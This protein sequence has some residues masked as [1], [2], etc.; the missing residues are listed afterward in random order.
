M[1]KYLP[2]LLTAIW[3]TA[4]S[5]GLHVLWVY[6]HT[7]GSA[8]GVPGRWPAHSRIPRASE[9]PT[10]IMFAHPR[11]PCTRASIGELAVLMTHCQNQVKACV[12]FFQPKG[13]SQDWPHTDLWRSAAA[14]PGVTVRSDEDGME[15]KCFQATTSG[16]VVLYD[17]LGKLVFSGGITSSRGHAGDNVGRSKLTQWLHHETAAGSETPVFGC[18][19]LDPTPGCNK[20]QIA[21]VR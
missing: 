6:E 7:P 10:L 21:W 2:W 4:V 12:V 8:A 20:K 17:A 11:C 14:I 18:S 19:L 13:S 16:H 9:C 15:A 1:K 3:L 5:A